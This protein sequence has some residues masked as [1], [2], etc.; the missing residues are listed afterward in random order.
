MFTKYNIETSGS[1]D[2]DMLQLARQN[3]R[4]RKV[5][6]VVRRICFYAVTLSQ[7]CVCLSLTSH[8]R[9]VKAYNACAREWSFLIGTQYSL[10]FPTTLFLPRSLPSNDELA[11]AQLLHTG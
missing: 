10:I 5:V 4:Q 9:M 1:V 2:L 7:T 6:V 3:Y 11:F 8:K